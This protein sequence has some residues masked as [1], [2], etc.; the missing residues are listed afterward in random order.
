[1]PFKAGS[2]GG[3]GR[4]STTENR[5]ASGQF[6]KAVIFEGDRVLGRGRSVTGEAIDARLRRGWV[7][8]PDHRV[9]DN[10]RLLER[11]EMP[12][13]QENLEVALREALH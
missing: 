9:G 11:S 4:C 5:N 1:V 13:S 2:D 10:G 12:E 6:V 8:S 7:K 3:S